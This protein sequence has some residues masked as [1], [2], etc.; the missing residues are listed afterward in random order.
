MKKKNIL[1]SDDIELFLRLERTFLLREEFQLITANSGREVLAAASEILLDAIFLDLYLPDMGGDEC[2]KILKGDELYHRIPVIM[3]V[4][5]GRDSDIERCQKAGC[6]AI[7]S[8]PINRSVFLD[9]VRKFLR[10]KERLPPR[11]PFRLRTHY[12]TSPR[13]LLRG[14]SVNLST[15][16]L[17]IETDVPVA[18]NTLLTVEIFVPH[19][20]MS[21]RC[22]ASVTWINQ[23]EHLQNLGLPSG[24]GLR[25]LDLDPDDKEFIHEFILRGEPD[26]LESHVVQDDAA[27]RKE[28]ETAKILIVD[29]NLGNRNRLRS[30][31]ER[32]QYQIV[33][34]ANSEEAIALVGKEH[35]DLIIL[36]ASLQGEDGHD[37]CAKLRQNHQSSYLP[38]ILLSGWTFTLGRSQAL[39]AGAT[40]AISRPFR[41]MEIFNKVRNCLN[42]HQLSE[43]L[44]KNRRQL[45][46]KDREQ[47][48]SM[49]AAAIIQQCLLPTAM[50]K[51]V[52]YNFAWRFM[53]CER[54]G[55]D[56]FN[57]FQLDENH[58]GA[59]IMDVSGQG[60][61][62]AMMATS[63]AQALNPSNSRFLK[64]I[65]NSPPYYELVSP[66]ALLAKLNREYPIE[67]FE[68][69]FTICY[70][71][72]DVQSGKLCYSNAAHP[73]P[74]LVRA[75]GRV[76]KLSAGGTI[77]G[78]GEGMSYE[79][80]TMQMEN[81]DRLFLF[82][83]GIIE[84]VDK[85]GEFY[86]EER[87]ISALQAGT[88]DT[89][90]MAC[91]SVINSLMNF[92]DRQKPGDDITLVGIEYREPAQGAPP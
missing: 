83:D 86:G 60:V 34:A 12:W 76:E 68:K 35:P 15:G 47:E 40:D 41:E 84:H 14:N 69:H 11:Y 1:I 65:T 58:V 19:D 80:G 43:S 10:I 42:I 22:N 71:L 44:S 3:V 25:F 88:G 90:Q 9:T 46:V 7:V 55:G 27:A 50:P 49:R 92:G 59:Y 48:E 20:G 37:L 31:L 91:A 72:L 16:G 89:L 8:R 39:E 51:V 78:I 74:L 75:G 52:S 6:D 29:D 87:L 38:V 77:I 45:L 82:T 66:S 73:F 28:E 2:C 56:L 23:P 36:D 63:V 57:I 53:P 85:E 67:R 32:E 5:G 61:A 30:I 26:P 62:A 18:V 70:L 33:E 4:N 81:G 13:Q 64:M 54:I 24:M 21:I 17:F 79:E